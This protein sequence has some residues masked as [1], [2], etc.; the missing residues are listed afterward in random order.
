MAFGL[1]LR[2]LAR[3]GR[4]RGFVCGATANDLVATAFFAYSTELL[5]KAGKVLGKDMRYYEDMHSKIVAAFREYFME[6]GMPKDEFPMTE[7]LPE[8][9]KQVDTTRKGMTQTALVLILHFGLCT[10][11]ER[12]ALTQKLVELIKA[13]GGKMTTGFLGTPYILQS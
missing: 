7:I 12:P 5:V 9:A 6:N 10:E 4:G 1:P 3:D 13:F 11:E 2:R 8:G